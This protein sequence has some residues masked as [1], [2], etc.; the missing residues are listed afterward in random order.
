MTAPAARD[1][2]D[3]PTAGAVDRR[4]RAAAALAAIWAR[5]RPALIEEA[6]G[7]EAVAA[8]L[9]KAPADPELRD[10][11]HRASHKLAG[12]LGTFGLSEGTRLARELEQAFDG[13]ILAEDHLARLPGL[14]VA[15][16]REL[17]AAP[18]DRTPGSAPAPQRP[19]DP[20]AG[21]AAADDADRATVLV[22][23]DS[24]VVLEWNSALLRSAGYRVVA[25]PAG[26]R[27]IELAVREPPDV[28]VVDEEMPG[29]SGRQVIETLRAQGLLAGIVMLTGSQGP[30]IEALALRVGAD[31]WLLKP[32]EDEKLIRAV[33]RAREIGLSRL[34]RRDREAEMDGEL[35]AAASI[36]SALLPSDAAVPAGYR[37]DW[38]ALPSR[39]VG[40]DLLDLFVDVH[41][42][43]LVVADVSGKGV[44]AAL[45]A[46]MIR[47]A[48]RGSFQRGE[49]P[50]ESL[51][52]AG[53]LL[54]PDLVRTERFLTACV[55]RLEPEGGR[56]LYADAGHGHHL[57]LLPDGS[58]RPLE[59]SGIALGFIP[60]PEFELGVEVL[61]RGARL[62]IFSDGLVEGRGEPADTLADLTRDLANGRDAR[63]LVAE[64]A[65][66]DDRTL[67]VLERLA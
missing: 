5:S 36:Q 43:H 60:D 13:G 62:A 66:D 22:I 31:D 25:A 24:E 14:A 41:G 18:A 55:L 45:L 10:R 67:M 26:A 32:C 29:L 12:S 23:D 57:L 50:A 19:E 28:V 2:G 54:F 56:L 35:R 16:R 3:P 15:L 7:L 46:A 40:G 8:A 1:T 38:A 20:S 59:K 39:D 49:D 58:S 51:A 44:G 33:A 4:E 47:T 61:D 34:L 6:A 52:A 42:I 37:L 64:A 63:S 21:T 27:G 53:R 48:L 30:R 9:R 65:P 11:G 17:E